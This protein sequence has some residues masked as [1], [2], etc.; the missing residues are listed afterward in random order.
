MVKASQLTIYGLSLINAMLANRYYS[1]LKNTTLNEKFMI[2]PYEH[3]PKGTVSTPVFPKVRLFTIGIGGREV[4]ENVDE[5]R[6]SQH[7]PV[8]AAL[9]KHIPFVIRSI[10][11]DVTPEQRLNYRLRRL[12]NINGKTYIVYYAK[13]CTLV[14]YRPYSFLVHKVNG[15]DTLSIFDTNSDIFLN[16]V[17]TNKPTDLKLALDAPTILNRF[18]FEFYLNSF[19]QA[20]LL[21]VF[22]ILGLADST[23][24]TE[25]GICHGYDTHASYGLESVDTQITY[26]IDTELD[27]ILDFDIRE[28]FKRNIELGGAEPMFLDSTHVT[29]E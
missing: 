13:V 27:I 24:I 2:N 26:H 4:I 22:K 7:S 5:Y 23:R 29:R 21:N 28:G 25:I 1:V 3:T 18:K 14:D 12:E 6:F 17:P 9:F 10:D 16:P 8:D 11:N 19:D 20:E 15:N